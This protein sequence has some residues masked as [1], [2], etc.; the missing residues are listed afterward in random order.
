MMS[1][2]NV[3]ITYSTRSTNLFNLNHATLFLIKKRRSTDATGGVLNKKL[4]VKISQFSQGNTCLKE[5]PTQ[6]CS[7]EYCEISKKTYFEEQLRT[8]ASEVILESDCLGLYFW[9]VTFKTFRTYQLLSKQAFKT[10]FGAYA[11]LKFNPYVFFWTQVSYV[12]H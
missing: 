7:Y 2:N 9:R 6:I 5:P 4:F 10:Q 1:T 8:A 12:Y 3:K 11:I